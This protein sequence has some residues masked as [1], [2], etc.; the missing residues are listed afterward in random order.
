MAA[1]GSALLRNFLDVYSI[2]TPSFPPS[3][4]VTL[5]CVGMLTGLRGTE[6]YVM[7][8][9]R[10]DRQM[11]CCS[12]DDWEKR[13]VMEVAKTFGKCGRQRLVLRR[14]E[15]SRHVIGIQGERRCISPA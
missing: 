4:P 2:H 14:L 12:E 15:N 8:P 7:V 9:H 11:L 5:G 10:K 1:A 6:V 13:G 3:G